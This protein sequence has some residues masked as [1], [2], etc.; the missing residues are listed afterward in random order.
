M[1]SCIQC[2]AYK[3]QIIDLKAELE[4]IGETNLQ[5]IV[6]SLVSE[7]DK[8]RKQIDQNQKDKPL[9]TRIDNA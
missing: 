7:N 5:L 3:L 9:L 6:M 2:E 4:K 8:L 1:G